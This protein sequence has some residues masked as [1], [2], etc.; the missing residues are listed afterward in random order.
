M[1]VEKAYTSRCGLYVC[2][3]LWLRLEDQE[4]EVS[5]SCVTAVAIVYTHIANCFS[6]MY[7][8][9]CDANSETEVRLLEI[10]L[11]VGRFLKL[12]TISN[13]S[14]QVGIVSDLSKSHA[15][16]RSLCNAD[17]LPYRDCGYRLV[18]TESFASL[19]TR[20]SASSSVDC[21]ASSTTLTLPFKLYCEH[22]HILTQ[23]CLDP[24][25]Q[26]SYCRVYLCSQSASTL[27]STPKAS[28]PARA[29]TSKAGQLR[30]CIR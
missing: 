29:T 9:L 13:S 5:A 14:K 15:R 21:F 18:I 3:C 25:R 7:Q 6:Y 11:V 10:T 2:K 17:T 30:W 4:K 28:S 26:C 22:T 23:R 8:C 1:Y 20:T 24:L 27:S 16:S 12:L 19:M